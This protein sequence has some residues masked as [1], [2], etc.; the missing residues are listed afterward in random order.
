MTSVMIR[1][2]RSLTEFAGANIAA[3]VPT[4]TTP[5]DSYINP[6]NPPK[7]K[8]H[9]NVKYWYKFRN[10][11]VLDGVSYTVTFNIRD[12]GKE[13][14]QYLIEFKEDKTPGLSH[15]VHKS[16]LRQTDQTSY[17]NSVPQNADLSTDSDK[18][19]LTRT[20]SEKVQVTEESQSGAKVAVFAIASV[21]VQI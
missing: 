19:D 11:I 14:L 8:A 15:T 4:A 7:N 6:S 21:A 1:S 13:Q 20:N 5:E 17:S 2:L 16:D 18:K 3:Y 12:K 9:K 10:R